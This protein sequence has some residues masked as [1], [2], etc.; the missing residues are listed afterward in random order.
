VGGWV[1]LHA[2][3]RLCVGRGGLGCTNLFTLN[4]SCSLD[5]SDLNSRR[6]AFTNEYVFVVE[7]KGFCMNDGLS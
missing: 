5:F 6:N 3:A 4:T 2:P 1:G 7:L